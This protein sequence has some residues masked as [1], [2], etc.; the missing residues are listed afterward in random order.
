MRIIATKFE[1]KGVFGHAIGESIGPFDD[2]DDRLFKEL[3]DAE[4]QEFVAIVDS[5]SIDVIDFGL[6]GDWVDQHKRR[7]DDLFGIPTEGLGEKLDQLRLTR[8]EGT[9]ETD[10]AGELCREEF[11]QMAAEGP[12][13]F[14]A[15][16]SHA[17]F[18]GSGVL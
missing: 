5:I 10:D 12:A 13:V 4:F 18:V 7:T 1:P 11:C 6:G 14:E 2:R 17:E 8:P 9:D 15:F 3:F 16:E